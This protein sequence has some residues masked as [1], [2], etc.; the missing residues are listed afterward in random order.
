[1]NKEL[2]F[3]KAKPLPYAITNSVEKELNKMVDEGVT[4]TVQS[5]AA[6]IIAV[7]KKYS[8]HTRVLRFYSYVQFMC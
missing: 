8:D 4:K 5:C 3:Y 6:P 2:Q 7:P 1:M